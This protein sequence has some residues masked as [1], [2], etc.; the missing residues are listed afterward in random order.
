MASFAF[1]YLARQVVEEIAERRHQREE[2]REARR[3][4]AN[5]CAVRVTPT[6]LDVDHYNGVLFTFKNKTDEPLTDLLVRFNGVVLRRTHLSR[7]GAGPWSFRANLHE[8]GISRPMPK[9]GA[10]AILGS[11]VRPRVEFEFSIGTTRFLRIAKTVVVVPDP[12]L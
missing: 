3:A 8:V 6:S 1:V 5:A 9:T 10:G 2:V 7:P 12:Q 11:E 4:T